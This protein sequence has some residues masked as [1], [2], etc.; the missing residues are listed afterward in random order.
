MKLSSS[1][2]FSNPLYRISPTPNRFNDLLLAKTIIFS[3]I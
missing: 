1:S 2:S 3:I